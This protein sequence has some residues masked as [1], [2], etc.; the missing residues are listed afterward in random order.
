MDTHLEGVT[1]LD[2]VA[3]PRHDVALA[4]KLK[5]LVIGVAHVDL[6][7]LAAVVDVG[8]TADGDLQDPHRQRRLVADRL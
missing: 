5:I 7:E 2:D 3:P 6:D 4:G 8:D 1:G